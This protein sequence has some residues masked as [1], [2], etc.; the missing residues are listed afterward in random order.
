LLILLGDNDGVLS[1]VGMLPMVAG[2]RRLVGPDWSKSEER[3]YYV[4]FLSQSLVEKLNII[5]PKVEMVKYLA[6]PLFLVSVLLRV[7]S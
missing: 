4:K 1:V 3:S 5:L 2:I 7:V 6:R